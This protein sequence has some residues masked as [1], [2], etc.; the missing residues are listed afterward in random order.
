MTTERKIYIVVILDSLRFGGKMSLID[1]IRG[2]REGLNNSVYRSFSP[3]LAELLVSD[4]R[5][6]KHV[7]ISVDSNP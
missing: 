5:M 4:V 1:K 3:E 7:S 6:P 2:F